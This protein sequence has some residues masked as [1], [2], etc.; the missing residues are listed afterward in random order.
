MLGL[1]CRRSN[2][3]PMLIQHWF[4]VLTPGICPI[5]YTDMENPTPILQNEVINSVFSRTQTPE[6]KKSLQD[7]SFT[8][9]ASRPPAGCFS[10]DKCMDYKIHAYMRVAYA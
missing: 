9:Y 10:Y 5:L 3:K 7:R 6:H 8:R 2:V 4:N 1:R